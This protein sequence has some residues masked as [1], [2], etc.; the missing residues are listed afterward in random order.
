MKGKYD[1]SEL[2]VKVTTFSN[3]GA[4]YKINVDNYKVETLYKSQLPDKT[5]NPDDYAQDQVFYKS[6]DGTKI[7]MFIVRK[8]STLPSLAQKPDKPITTLLY[9]YGGFGVSQQPDFSPTN[10][11][12]M[13]N[14]D[15]M[16]VVAN[17]RGGGEYGDEWHESATKS[18]K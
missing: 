9:G 12:L 5:F 18:K 13:R 10:L 7:P 14:L 8:K 17:I 2:I 1:E 16:Y 3:P 4:V 15:A 6:K 11:I